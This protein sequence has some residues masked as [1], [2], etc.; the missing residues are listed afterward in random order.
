M[1]A[2]HDLIW[3]AYNTFEM[4]NRPREAPDE[5]ADLTQE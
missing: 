1:P 5:A 2:W 3:Y 4:L